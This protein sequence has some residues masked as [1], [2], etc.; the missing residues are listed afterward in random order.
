MYI[1][2][3]SIKWSGGACKSYHH[4]DGKDHATCLKPRQIVLDGSGGYC[5]LHMKLLCNKGVGFHYIQE[6][7]ERKKALYCTHMCV[8]L[9]RLRNG[10]G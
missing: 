6:N 9:R 3:A 7:L 5:S 2:Y 1:I 4:R 8:W 10:A